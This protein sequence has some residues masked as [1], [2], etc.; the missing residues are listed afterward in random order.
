[1]NGSL[2]VGLALAAAAFVPQA[3]A[4]VTF[5][6][7]EG[8]A[9]K[10]FTT[11]KQV[12]NLDR[13]GFD[14][15]ASSVVVAGKDWEVCEEIRFEG[16][17]LILRPGRYPSLTAMGLNDQ[18]SSV[19]DVSKGA[20]FEESRYAPM[21]VASKVTFYEQ[22]NFRGRTFSTGQPVVNLGRAGFN[23]YASSVVVSGNNWE[24]C[25]DTRYDG[26]CIVLTPGRYPTLASMGLTER[27]SS[28]RAAAVPVAAVPAPGPAPVVNQDYRRRNEERIYS[29]PVTS[30]R[31]VVAAAPG[32]RCWMERA[33]VAPDRNKPSIPG[34]AVGAILG[35]I[36]G[37]QIGGGKGKDIATAGGAIAGGVLG[38]NVGGRVIGGA[39]ATQPQEVQRCENITTAPQP[40]YWDVTYTFRGIDHQ[41]QMSA[42]P[43]PTISV[44]ERGEPRA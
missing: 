33:E 25:D 35:G 23:A 16:R 2:K 29:V 19:R 28:V 27:V 1:M 37:H 9:G 17:C 3:L 31:A 26:R 41:V 12:G 22:E 42:P 40:D 13:A 24:V 7:R 6:E 4:Q 15:R 43:G 11:A 21:P 18:I 8:F 14:N 36:L 38:A 30:V 34:A 10:A 44:N 5:Y 20:R 39:Q 32:Q